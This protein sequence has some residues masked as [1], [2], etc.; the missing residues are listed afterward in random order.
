MILPIQTLWISGREKHRPLIHSPDNYDYYP[1]K[2]KRGH[3]Y[4]GK[5]G[6]FLFWVDI[7]LNWRDR[8]NASIFALRLKPR[9]HLQNPACAGFQTSRRG[10]FAMVDADL[11]ARMTEMA[12]KIN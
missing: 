12:L 9:L 3:F 1:K 11:S 6:T 8:A 2:T 4:F 7:G 10:G 5:Q